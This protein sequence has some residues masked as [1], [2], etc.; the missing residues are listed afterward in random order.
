M[1]AVDKDSKALQGTNW[2]MQSCRILDSNT[3]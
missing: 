2:G 3:S 1:E